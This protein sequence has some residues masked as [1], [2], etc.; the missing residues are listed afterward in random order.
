LIGVPN[1]GAVDAL[2]VDATGTLHTAIVIESGTPSTAVWVSYLSSF[3]WWNAYSVNQTGG[4]F[5]GA[6]NL[7]GFTIPTTGDWGPFTSS[8]PAAWQSGTNHVGNVLFAQNSAGTIGLWAMCGATAGTDTAH[9]MTQTSG[10]TF[11]DVTPSLLAGSVIT[12]MAY[13]A[14]EGLFGFLAYTGASTYLFV[15]NNP[16]NV[17]SWVECGAWT[18]QAQGLAVVGSVWAVG[19][20]YTLTPDSGARVQISSGVSAVFNGAGGLAPFSWTQCSLLDALPLTLSSSGNGLLV[21]TAAKMECSQ[22]Y[23][24]L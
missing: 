24:L 21:A 2:F 5:T 8:L 12:G 10:P 15:S 16:S 9:L 19:L 13:D 14:T 23:G 7:S 11:T 1:G 20:A 4:T 3:T 22:Q 6:F 18:G 17:S